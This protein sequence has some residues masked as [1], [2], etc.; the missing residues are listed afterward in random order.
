MRLAAPERLEDR[1]APAGG[2]DVSFDGDGRR[3]FNFGNT[4]TVRAV[5]VQSDGNIVAVGSWDGGFSDF[6]IVRFTPT[7]GLDPAFV[8]GFFGNGGGRTNVF[9]GD[10]VA[11]GSEVANA[12]AIQNDGKIVVAGYSNG[13]GGGPSATNDF[14]IARLDT[15]GKLD[16]S[17]GNGGKVT[18]DFSPQA[19]LP[20]DDRANAVV[21][22]NDGKIVVAGSSE[23]GGLARFTFLRLNS[24]GSPDPSFATGGKRFV[25]VGETSSA[26]FAT[27]LAL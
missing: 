4:D 6:A 1:L 16:P 26:D 27:A 18:F 11:A 15:A 25:Q 17:F 14:A 10:F 8:S 22:Q 19:G 7:G 2:L 3:T 20:S 9:F 13:N 5:K 23:F 12:V 24:D 21:V